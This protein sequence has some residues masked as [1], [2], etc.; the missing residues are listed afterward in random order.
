MSSSTSG[1]GRRKKKIAVNEDDIAIGKL[2]G[3]LSFLWDHGIIFTAG[4]GSSDLVRLQP[5]QPR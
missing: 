4:A 2:S 1:G 5:S 3:W